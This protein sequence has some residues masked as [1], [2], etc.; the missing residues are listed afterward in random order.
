MVLLTRIP[1]HAIV[2]PDQ[3]WIF[4]QYTYLC[5]IYTKRRC[6]TELN[7]SNQK[8]RRWRVNWLIHHPPPT[9]AQVWAAS[10]GLQQI[11]L[12][13]HTMKN[14]TRCGYSE[15]HLAVLL[16]LLSIVVHISKTLTREI[17]VSSNFN[18]RFTFVLQLSSYADR[19]LRYFHSWYLVSTWTRY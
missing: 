2:W 7:H 4:S 10:G 14:T 3:T 17:R 15:L 11:L 1:L 6:R 12:R 8:V 19:C 18:H 9:L 16:D 5:F 13:V